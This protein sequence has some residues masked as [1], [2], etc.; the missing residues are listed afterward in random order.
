M[1]ANASKEEIAAVNYV[2]PEAVAALGQTRFPGVSK[3]VDKKTKRIDQTTALAL[4]KIL[5]KDGMPMPP[6]LAEQVAAG[7][8]ICHLQARLL[9]EYNP[10]YAAYQLGLFVADFVRQYRE[11][12][13][14]DKYALPWKGF[15]ARLAQALGELKN[16][17]TNKDAV[18]YITSLYAAK[19]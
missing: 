4:L 8:G 5:R 1:P 13:K 9:D 14:D 17:G 10:D 19:R 15:A 12:D 11:H 3:Q 7:V 16:E 6:T 18:K 2:R